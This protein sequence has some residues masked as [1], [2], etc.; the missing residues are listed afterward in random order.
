MKFFFYTYL[1]GGDA[2][3]GLDKTKMEKLQYEARL[4]LAR[5]DFYEFCKLMASDFYRDDR[6]YIKKLCNDLQEFFE[7]DDM[8]LVI[9]MPPR[10]GKSRTAG[11]LT[12]WLFGKNLHNKIMTGSYNEFLSTTFSRNVRD[13]IMAEKF[14]DDIIVYH[15]IF[16]N[17]KVKKGDAAA[18]HWTLEGA[19]SSYLATS[20]GGS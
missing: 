12:P 8:V 11:L 19:Y 13:M 10:F 17:V 16:P 14:Q 5:R 1:K 7:G 20:P 18:A 15:D 9:N 2:M 4:E 6:P 3:P